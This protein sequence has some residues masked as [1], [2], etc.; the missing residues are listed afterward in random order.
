[1]DFDVTGMHVVLVDDVLYT[2]RTIRRHE[3][4]MDRGRPASI[5]LAVLVDRGHRAAHPPGFC[6]QE[7]PYRPQRG[8]P[9][10]AL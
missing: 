1:M 3:T 2:G 5:R 6:G 8:G 10:A 4:L 9:C 7:H